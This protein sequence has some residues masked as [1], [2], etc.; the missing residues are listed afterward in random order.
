MENKLVLMTA[1]YWTTSVF[2]VAK[3]AGGVSFRGVDYLVVNKEG[4]TVFELSD[5]TSKHYVNGDMVIQPGEPM[6]L[7]R[8]DWIPVYKA[9]GRE[10]IME[11][12]DKKVSLEE[13]KKLITNKKD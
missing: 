3:Y 13:A 12:L 6:D 5:P 9:L 1:E 7:V 11:L 2:S 10:K 4:V 8:E